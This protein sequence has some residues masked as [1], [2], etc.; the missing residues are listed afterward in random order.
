MPPTLVNTTHG[1]HQ[2]NTLLFILTPGYLPCPIFNQ[3][4]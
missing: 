3:P 1:D 2:S 4:D